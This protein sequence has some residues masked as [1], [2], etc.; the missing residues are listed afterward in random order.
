MIQK[1]LKSVRVVRRREA[2]PPPCSFLVASRLT[3]Y[4]V[5][6]CLVPTRPG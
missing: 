1:F 3:P 2:D 4:E 5:S 6:P